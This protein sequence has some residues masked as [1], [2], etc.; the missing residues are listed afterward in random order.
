MSLRGL[1]WLALAAGVA[2]GAVIPPATFAGEPVRLL[3]TFMG[4]VSASILPTVSLAIGSMSGTGRSVQKIAE[5]YEDLREN[6]ASLFR[7]LAW[8]ALAF[9]ALVVFAMTPTW[10]LELAVKGLQIKIPDAAR[11][12]IQI[13]IFASS[14][15]ALWQAYRIPQTF[16]KVL[17]IK[18]DISVYEARKQIRENA[19]GENEIR[20]M[21]S[22]KEGFG[23]TITLEELGK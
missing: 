17:K 7:T 22:K 5:L 13:V 9:G 6:T 14:A 2:C 19:P 4:L 1:R 18:R 21:F 8:V 15:M 20:Q 12:C 10:N 11:R 23:R 3:V 16:L